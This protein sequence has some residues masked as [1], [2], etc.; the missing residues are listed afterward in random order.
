M[1]LCSSGRFEEALATVDEAEALGQR[2]RFGMAAF[3]VPDLLHTRAAVLY[4]AG[5]LDEAVQVARDATA[6]R[7]SLG[8]IDGDQLSRLSDS[9]EL[10]ANALTR[11]RRLDEAETL[12]AEVLAMRARLPWAERARALLNR[13]A[14]LLEAGREEEGLEAALALV[15]GAFARPGSTGISDPSFVQGL[16]NLGVLLRRNGR[17][18][19]ALA[20]Q[21]IAVGELRSLAV[22][23]AHEARGDLARALANQS[24]M[25]LECG[26]P[27]DALA[28]GAEA[29][30]IREELAA[31]S[32]DTFG[33]E[34]ADSLNNQAVLFHKLG[35]PADGEEV[36]ERCVEIRRGLHASQPSAYERKLANAL[37]TH[38]EM[39]TRSGRADEAL[40]IGRE[41]V[42]RF[43]ALE[44][45]EPG[46][47]T[48]WLASAL[49][50]LA[51]V[52][53]GCGLEDAFATSDAAVACGRQAYAANPAGLGDTLAQVLLACAE[54]H[55]SDHGAAALAWAREA[56][57]VLAALAVEEPEAHAVALAQARELVA[58]LEG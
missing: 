10:Q 11:L 21:E 15:R 34:L 48:W 8:S 46:Q 24:L 20:V 43:L 23:G 27:D 50:T 40:D 14:T 3:V 49:D 25:H 5:R 31:V 37:A 57:E 7:R 2:L 13:S 6:A 26:R 22:L 30:A 38:A 39:L 9:L 29:L 53:A 18:S 4:E 12:S 42:D 19:E 55:A 16:S 47:H 28:P 32:W 36:A 33:P 52:Q 54:R 41:A 58:D 1:D 56:E 51:G 44:S 17:W 45:A 35:R